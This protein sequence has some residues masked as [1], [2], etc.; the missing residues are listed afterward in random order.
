MVYARGRDGDRHCCT[1]ATVVARFSQITFMHCSSRR[2]KPPGAQPFLGIVVCEACDSS[3]V[4]RSVL[5]IPFEPFE[6]RTT[7]HGV[8]AGPVAL[9]IRI[10]A[11]DQFHRFKLAV[12]VVETVQQQRL[13]KHRQLGTAKLVFAVMR[14]DQMLNQRLQLRGNASN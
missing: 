6:E 13:W 12:E 5:A 3:I 8:I 10:S 1:S 4:F 2:L 9:N 14:D 11:Q 7:E